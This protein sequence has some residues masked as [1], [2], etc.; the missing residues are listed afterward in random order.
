MSFPAY[1][2]AFLL[3]LAFTCVIETAVVSI[4]LRLVFQPSMPVRKIIFAG[5]FASFATI[6]Y[7]WFVFPALIPKSV[8]P[9]VWLSEPFVFLVE[10][11]FYRTYLRLSWREAFAISFAANAIS[12]LGGRA[13][14]IANLWPIVG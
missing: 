1:V 3:S 2:N 12:F 13:L 4:L 9:A 5:V 10:A 11:I 6:G 8:M 7:V 14:R